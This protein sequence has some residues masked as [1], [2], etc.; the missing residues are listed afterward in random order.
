V[1]KAQGRAQEG[2]SKREVQGESKRE[3]QGEIEVENGKRG[4][5]RQST[6][7]CANGSHQSK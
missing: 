6:S 4:S 5:K 2:E 7:M 1:I 3:V